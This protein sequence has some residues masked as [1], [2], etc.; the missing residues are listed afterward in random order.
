[1]YICVGTSNACMHACMH[2]HMHKN[3]HTYTY[4]Y[5]MHTHS[6]WHTSAH[7]HVHTRTHAHTRPS[8][9][10]LMHRSR[11]TSGRN[12]SRTPIT[13]PT[14][15]ETVE[16]YPS[17]YLCGTWSR[18]FIDRVAS[19]CIC[20]ELRARASLENGC[21]PQNTISQVSPILS[22]EV[23]G[24]SKPRARQTQLARKANVR[25]A[26]RRAFPWCK[27]S[28]QKTVLHSCT[29]CG[30]KNKFKEFAGN[31]ILRGFDDCTHQPS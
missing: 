28:C 14:A 31:G 15:R 7:T 18:P 19:C 4:A 27:A 1:M 16:A 20:C 29:K 6:D 12:T 5:T 23:A 25:P 30:E 17:L 21:N 24:R 11:H 8:T 2:A 26:R 10:A 3:T 13:C 9:H 22:L